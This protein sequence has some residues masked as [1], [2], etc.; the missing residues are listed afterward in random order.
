MFPFAILDF[1]SNCPF[2]KTEVAN[3]KIHHLDLR[4][5]PKCLSAFFPCDQTMALRGDISDKSR[6]LW[7]KAL[8]A[9]NPEDPKMDHVCCIDHGE[10]LVDGNLPDY[11]IPGKVTTCCKMFHLPPSLTLQILKRTIDAPFQKPTANGKHHF[12]FIRWLDSLV[13]K[14]IGEKV[15]DEDPLDLIQYNLHLKKFF[16]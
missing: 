13:S 10:P 16:E 3:V 15:P 7:Y 14:M 8:L 2:C 11:G 9:K 12:F 5:C 4:I 6:E 1:M